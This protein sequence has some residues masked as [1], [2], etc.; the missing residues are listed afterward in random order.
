MSRMAD[1]HG[2]TN[3]YREKGI[4]RVVKR[5]RPRKHLFG[6]GSQSGKKS[7][8]KVSAAPAE[9]YT[10]PELKEQD[11]KSGCLVMIVLAVMIIMLIVGVVSCNNNNKKYIDHTS[12]TQAE[13]PVLYDEYDAVKEFY[14][15]YENVSVGSLQSH[16][17]VEKPV[18]TALSYLEYDRVYRF[19]LNLNNLDQKFTLDEAIE[20][21]LDYIPLEMVQQNFDFEKAIQKTSDD[22][23]KLY[24]CYYTVKESGVE[25]PGY[26]YDGT[27]WVKLQPGL[28]LVIEETADG[29][30]IVNI[31][32]D[33][34]DLEYGGNEDYQKQERATHQNWNFSLEQ[35]NESK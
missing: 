3:K 15:H 27:D 16:E 19:I 17:E 32:D 23:T 10:A 8:K 34:Y 14:L 35:Y 7:T 13:H 2:L 33:W 9:N 6:S 11:V 26:Y 21:A 30:Y 20:I 24:E 5:G 22:G 1:K 18:V 12:I 28:S 4:K 25:K 31:G 29:S